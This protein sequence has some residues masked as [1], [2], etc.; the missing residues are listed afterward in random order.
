MKQDSV[1]NKEFKKKDVERL[2]NLIQGKYGERTSIGIGYQ[3]P[4]ESHKEGDIWEEDGRKWTIKDGVKQ[5]IT[6]LDKAK[7][8]HLVP[9]F[10]T[11][12]KKPMKKRFDKDYYH[13]HK[14][15]FDCVIDF[16][17]NLKKLGLWEEYEK[18]IINS[19]IEGFI[20]DFKMFAEEELNQKNESFITEQ[21]DVEKW[22][23]GINKQKVLD[24]IDKVIENIEKN[25][26]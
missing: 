17:H 4:Q 5:N 16:E 22:T 11:N 3:K 19:D 10:C 8:L 1:L 2:R 13:I 12:C 18:N 15:C 14:M 26:K 21:G 9:I 6:K 20:K 23:G 24:T 7:K 25:K